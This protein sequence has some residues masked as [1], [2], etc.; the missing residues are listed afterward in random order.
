MPPHLELSGIA[1]VSFQGNPGYSTPFTEIV[2][3]NASNKNYDFLAIERFLQQSHSVITP[4]E[5]Y[6]LGGKVL[7][8]FQL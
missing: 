4:L 5:S 7:K 8:K 1:E 6:F 2:W 3:F